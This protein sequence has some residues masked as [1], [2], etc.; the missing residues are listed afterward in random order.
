MQ[1]LTRTSLRD[2]VMIC[3]SVDLA[4]RQIKH[5][6]CRLVNLVKQNY[7]EDGV[8]NLFSQWV[9]DKDKAE[10]TYWSGTF[11]DQHTADSDHSTIEGRFRVQNSLIDPQAPKHPIR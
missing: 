5:E 2:R 4:T 3:K 8:N 7:G 9:A 6:W 10:C 1:G 11:V